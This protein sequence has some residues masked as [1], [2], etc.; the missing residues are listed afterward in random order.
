MTEEPIVENAEPKSPPHSPEGNPPPSVTPIRSRRKKIL[1]PIVLA[2]IGLALLLG[3]FLTYPRRPQPS[4][5]LSGFVSVVG[6]SRYVDAHMGL[7]FYTVDQL[8]PDLS[9]VTVQVLMGSSP[10]PGARADMQ[11]S[12]LG[13]TTVT[14]CSPSCTEMGGPPGTWDA[15]PYFATDWAATAYFFVRARSFA[16][17]ANGATAEAAFPGLI[18]TGSHPTVVRLTYHIPS[19][20]TYDWSSTPAATLTSSRAVWTEPVTPGTAFMQ[21]VT[22]PRVATGINHAAETHDSTLTLWAGVLFGLGGG[23]LVAAVQEAL[24]D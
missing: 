16:V 4:A 19:A 9:R 17:A 20:N 21:G 14:R 24:H 12:G 8:H 22:Q 18:F 7:I 2:V 15:E 6:F 5:P 10:P 11:L 23:A 1:V 3:G 13:A